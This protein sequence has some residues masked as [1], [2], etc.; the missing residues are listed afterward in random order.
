MGGARIIGMTL[1]RPG[2]ESDYEGRPPVYET[3]CTGI[4]EKYE[5]APQG[6]YNILLRGVSRFRI[7]EEHAGEPYRLAAVEELLDAPGESGTLDDLRRQ[8]LSAIGAASDGPHT[9]VE[10]DTEHAL[11]VNALSQS[12]PFQPLERQSLLDCAGIEERY[13]RLLDLL[14][15][16]ALEDAYGRGGAPRVH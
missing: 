9:L 4:I 15:F 8:V 13:V 16:R 11:F 5:P 6:R 3:G 7:V 2:W 12:L 14:K 10:S 1:L